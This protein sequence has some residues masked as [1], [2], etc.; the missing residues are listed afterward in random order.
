VVLAFN[1][2]WETALKWAC[3]GAWLGASAGVILAFAAAGSL[4]LVARN[5]ER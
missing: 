1:R 4:A 5:R 2:D 3:H